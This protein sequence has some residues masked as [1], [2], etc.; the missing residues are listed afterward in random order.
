V[1]KKDL[2]NASKKVIYNFLNKEKEAQ[3]ENDATKI[4]KKKDFYNNDKKNKK[5]INALIEVLFVVVNLKFEAKLEL[6][7]LSIL[8]TSTSKKVLKEKRDR[9]I[10]ENKF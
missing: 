7:F 10:K 3:I 2:F 6:E 9:K 1:S 8:F 4:S 5:E